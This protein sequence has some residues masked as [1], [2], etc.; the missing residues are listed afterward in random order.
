MVLYFVKNYR[1]DR[2]KSSYSSILFSA[3]EIWLKS[4]RNAFF[5]FLDVSGDHR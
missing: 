5:V 2:V 1:I 3:C 4:R